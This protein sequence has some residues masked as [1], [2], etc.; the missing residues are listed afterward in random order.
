MSCSIL[1]CSLIEWVVNG[2][3][4][5]FC[6]LALLFFAPP[7]AFSAIDGDKFRVDVIGFN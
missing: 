5:Y 7:I 3:K 4:Y 2:L 1:A 6:I